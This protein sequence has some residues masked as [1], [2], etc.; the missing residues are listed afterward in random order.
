MTLFARDPRRSGTG[1]AGGRF[2]HKVPLAFDERSFFVLAFKGCYYIWT[3]VGQGSLNGPTIFGRLAAFLGRMS[4]GLIDGDKASVQMY[5]DDPIVSICA[6]GDDTANTIARLILFWRVMGF[7]LATHKAQMHDHVTWVGYDIRD[8]GET[9]AV[10]I[11]EGFMKDL[12]TDARAIM[13]KNMVS[14]KVLTKFTGKCNHVANLVYAWR[15]FLD[16]L[17]T[18]VSGAPNKRTWA[19][20]GMVWTMQ[21]R[22]S[23]SWIIKFLTINNHVLTR[24]WSFQ[25]YS[26]ERARLTA[27]LDASPWGLGGVLQL[28]GKI[29]SWFATPLTRHDERIHKR[30]IGCAKG[31]QV[32]ECLCFLVAL[33][34][35]KEFWADRKLSITIRSDN[36]AALFLGA[37]M[38]FKASALV[39]KEVALEYSD[40]SFEPRVFEHVPGISNVLADKLSRLFEP[41]AGVQVPEELSAAMKAEVPTR[42]KK[43]Y[44]ILATS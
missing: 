33:R 29:I 35:W 11:N 37:Q 20:K 39:A 1:P 27:T 14:K 34:V 30:R 38:K 17:W 8:E 16:Q 36:L 26:E 23:I 2:E 13:K 6:N 12:L 19:P 5:V 9:T 7:E 41:G 28:D 22:S 18:A 3:R 21:V 4:Q 32:W 42:T 43:Y 24:R 10:S 31:Q 15:P 40:T 25:E 44:K